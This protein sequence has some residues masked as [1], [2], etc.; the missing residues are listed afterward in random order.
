MLGVASLRELEGS[1]PPPQLPPAL[2]R[3]VR[4]VLTENERV[5][6]AIN[7]MD[8]PAFGELMNASHHSLSEDYQVSTPA[9]DQLAAALQADVDVFGAKLTGAGFGGA[10]VA[11]VRAGQGEAAAARVMGAFR[12]S[13]PA[14]A[15]LI[16]G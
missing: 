16:A 11:L 15:V 5:R 9:L 6:R 13:H 7:G 3:R 4:H 8:A 1:P 14:A 10:C 2:L 12:P